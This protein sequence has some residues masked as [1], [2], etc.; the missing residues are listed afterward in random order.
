MVDMY[1]NALEIVWTDTGFDMNYM[2][3]MQVHFVP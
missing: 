1:G 2:D 3:S